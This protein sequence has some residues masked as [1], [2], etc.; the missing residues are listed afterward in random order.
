MGTMYSILNGFNICLWD[1][2]RIAG[3]NP[4]LFEDRLLSNAGQRGIVS[5]YSKE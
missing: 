1:D 5:A 2:V 4:Y 3:L